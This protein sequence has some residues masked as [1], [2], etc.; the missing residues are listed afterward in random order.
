MVESVVILANSR[1]FD[2]RCIA[3]K[4]PDG[5][6]IRFVQDGKRS[7]PNEEGMNIK[8]LG[9]YSVNILENRISERLCY[10]TENYTYNNLNFVEYANVEELDYYLDNP[11]YIYGDLRRFI[12]FPEAKEYNNSLLFIKVSNFIA[13]KSPSGHVQCNFIYNGEEYSTF[14]LTD[15]YIESIFLRKNIGSNVFV[16]DAYIT[17]S[18]GVPSYF[19]VFK[20]VSGVIPAK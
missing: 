5:R 8:I 4:T 15:S 3:G 19:N 10:H 2:G 18:I 7:I 16:G 14:C 11:D 20:L 9:R 13:Y 17:V 1:K 12:R 6:W